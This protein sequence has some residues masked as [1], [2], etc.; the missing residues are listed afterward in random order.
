[1]LA[2]VHKRGRA[3]CTIAVTREKTARVRLTNV[4]RFVP[5][6]IKVD[7]NL[8]VH[9]A[10]MSSWSGI[11]QRSIS[12]HSG[13]FLIVCQEVLEILRRG[14]VTRLGVAH[15]MIT[16]SPAEGLRGRVVQAGLELLGAQVGVF[17]FCLDVVQVRRVAGDA[18]VSL[19]VA[20]GHGLLDAGG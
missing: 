7:D 3:R 8:A 4:D 16:A 12:C 13:S 17:T 6:V 11:E 19:A 15:A 18:I 10:W 1:M 14:S 20:D 5:I 9:V 2:V